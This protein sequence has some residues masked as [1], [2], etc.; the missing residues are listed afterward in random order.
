MIH[1]GDYLTVNGR[2]VLVTDVFLNCVTV[3]YRCGTEKIF[4]IERR[5]EDVL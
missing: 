3:R 2:K 4:F 5:R 1:I